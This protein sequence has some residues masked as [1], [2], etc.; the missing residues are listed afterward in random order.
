MSLARNISTAYYPAGRPA[1]VCVFI[2]ITIILANNLGL[3]GVI[4]SYCSLLAM[5][6]IAGRAKIVNSSAVQSST[7]NLKIP[8]V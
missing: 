8:S 3:C 5:K 2:T 4:I 7:D 1:G 6:I